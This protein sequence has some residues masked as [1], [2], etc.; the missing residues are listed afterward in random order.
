LFKLASYIILRDNTD[1]GDKVFLE[2]KTPR[3]GEETPLATAQL[4][5]SLISIKAP[6]SFFKTTEIPFSL[7]IVLYQQVVH[8]F[9]VVPANYQAFI[10]SQLLSQYPKALITLYKEDPLAKIWKEEKVL[11]FGQLKQQSSHLYPLRTFKDFVEI[12]PLSS[13]LG[14]LSKLDVSETV[15][16]QF[17]LVSVGNGWQQKGQTL[18]EPKI[19]AEGTTPSEY[20]AYS[21]QIKDKLAV[22]GFKTGI[23]ILCKSHN[24]SLLGLVAACFNSYNNPS[25][26][27]LSLAIPRFWQRKKFLSSMIE[28]S[29]TFTPTNQILNLLEI[30]TCYHFPTMKLANIKNIPWSRTILSDPPENLP[31]SLDIIDEQKKEI[32]FLGRTEYKNRATVFGIRKADR[33]QHLYI[34][35]KT[36]VGKSTL[37]ANMAINDIRNGEGVA[38][39]DPHGDLSEIILNYIPS[40]R[41]NDV[42]YLNP[43]DLEHPFRLNPLEIHNNV[44]K[45][46]IASGIVSIFYK[47]YGFSW[48]PRLEYTLRNT[49]LSLLEYPDPTL[50]MVPE[51]L[52][53][54]RFRQKVVDRLQD[55]VLKNFWV[56]EFAALSESQRVE[57]ISPILNKV[58]QF[59]S[60]PIIR[61]IVG[62]SKS[63]INLE[64]I[65][66]EGKIVIL[67]LSQGKIGEDNGSLLG[68]MII[69]KIQLA[70]MSRVLIQED[71]RKDFYLYV[72]EFQNFATSSFIKILS[73]A[74]KYRLNLILANQYI[75]QITPEVRSAIFG[76]AGTLLTFIVGA[77]DAPFL[78]KEFGERFTERD[79]LAL[80]KYQVIIK[81]AI[82]GLTSSPFL[83]QTLPLPQNHNQNKEKVIKVSQERYTKIQTRREDHQN[84]AVAIEL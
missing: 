20:N 34:I 70:A 5:S 3:T 60:S 35:G 18:L 66:N 38:I 75:S 30:A 28:R 43:A 4:L 25:G 36:G 37:I 7:E 2:I 46:L 45:E 68:A 81:M 22:P 73:E 83:A 67:N 27:S 47:L 9:L 63:T 55:P 57:T 13:L 53:N 56:N 16:I 71:L 48:G 14:M 11:Q 80:G 1:M 33:R 21:Q 12:D 26:N 62:Y 50:M 51:I 41:I 76:N 74:R 58:G 40:H 31:V 15:L 59:L 65:M 24:T 77:E 79:V 42:I 39:V 54:A 64:E 32:N 69:T 6:S 44:Q 82:D 19:T 84:D 52:T 10:E 23:R 29:S 72:D 61:N 49:L 78:A 8:F 17:I